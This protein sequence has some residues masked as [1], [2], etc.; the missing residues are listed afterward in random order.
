MLQAIMKPVHFEAGQVIFRQ[1]DPGDALYVSLKGEIGLQMPGSQRRLAS[2]A[3][4]VSVGEMAVLTHGTRSAE[5]VAES[6]VMALR[7]SVESF[8]HMKLAQP[9]LA[10]KILNNIALHL[11]GRVRMLTGDLAHWVSRSTTG[12][13]PGVG[14]LEKIT[15]TASREVTD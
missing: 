6:D 15:A 13:A 7:L 5:A 12:R 11:A 1:G 2:F 8:D 10:A 4:G 3:P 14:A 9:A